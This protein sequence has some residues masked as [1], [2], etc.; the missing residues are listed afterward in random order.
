[1]IPVD[2]SKQTIGIIEI[3]GEQHNKGRILREGDKDQNCGRGLEVRRIG[4]VYPSK[5]REELSGGFRDVVLKDGEEQMDGPSN[6]A[7]GAAKSRRDKD[8]IGH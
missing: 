1:M 3:L 8:H 7:G 2:H 6:K 5:G 4:D